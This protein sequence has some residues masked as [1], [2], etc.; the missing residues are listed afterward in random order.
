M[1]NFDTVYSTQSKLIM[2]PQRPLHDTL[3]DDPQPGIFRWPSG[4]RKGQA[5]GSG[6]DQRG[7]LK[8][9]INNR[10]HLPHRLTW[11]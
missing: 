6:H 11:P 7:C 2:L 3:H 4:K 9:S 10:R 8:V 5:A 1:I